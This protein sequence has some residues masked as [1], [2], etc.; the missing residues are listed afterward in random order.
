MMVVFSFFFFFLGGTGSNSVFSLQ[1]PLFLLFD[2]F[3]MTDEQ[4]SLDKQTQIEYD[5][6]T[7]TYF[8]RCVPH[9]SVALADFV[10]YNN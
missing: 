6:H 10:L 8:L 5:S 7:R 4:N 3:L 2:I 1:V 9:L